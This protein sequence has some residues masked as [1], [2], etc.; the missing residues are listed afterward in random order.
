MMGAGIEGFATDGRG[1]KMNSA[2]YEF[3]HVVTAK[4]SQPGKFPGRK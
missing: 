4:I 1:K 2:T 3:L